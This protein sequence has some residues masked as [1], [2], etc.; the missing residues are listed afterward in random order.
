MVQSKEINLEYYIKKV[1]KDQLINLYE[2]SDLQTCNK[3]FH[4]DTWILKILLKHYGYNVRSMSESKHLAR[5]R[6][7]QIHLENLKK[8]ISKELLLK[9]FNMD[10]LSIQQIADKL[11]VYRSDIKQLFIHYNIPIV[12]RQDISG[13]KHTQNLVNKVLAEYDKDMFSKL[14]YEKS[15]K[16]LKELLGVGNNVLKH[17]IDYY[18]LKPRDID[19][20]VRLRCASIQ[21][22]VFQKNLDT[23]S[24]S[25][26]EELYVDM[27]LSE[28]YICKLLHISKQMLE[29]LC[30]YYN[31]TRDPAVYKNS[32]LSIPNREFKKLLE[33]N[34]VENYSTE[35][36]LRGS[37]RKKFF[38]DFK[39]DKYL[40][41]IDPWITHN[42]S[43]EYN[44][45]YSVKDKYYHQQKS[46][47]AKEH[48]YICFH[49][50]DWINMQDIIDIILSQVDFDI[51]IQEPTLH[52]YDY[53]NNKIVNEAN[54]TSVFIYDDGFIL[55]KK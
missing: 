3:Y 41:E 13:K 8:N 11:N 17:V 7:K 22:N 34:T 48:G 21:K 28:T 35:F 51:Q 9:L 12:N 52:I 39:I 31:L 10:L 19:D 42:S 15:Y 44:K 16:E 53:K 1:P 14:Y 38:Y 47:V 29:R 30:S 32:S 50:F 55:T 27:A 18:N 40:I 6:K 23:I 46:I 49:I 37:D 33:R 43:A 54:K 26:L 5:Q 24:R 45:N 2:E 4:V 36:F 20:T 25:D